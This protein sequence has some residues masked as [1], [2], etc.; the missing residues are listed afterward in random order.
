[1]EPGVR[2]LKEVLFEIIGEINL[3]I[4]Q[5]TDNINIP[6]HVSKDDIKSKYLKNA[7]R[8]KS[9]LYHLYLNPV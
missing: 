4:L 6:I 5:S 2:K 8:L 7:M 1:M 9:K 3:E